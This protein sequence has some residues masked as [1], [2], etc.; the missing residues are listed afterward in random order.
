MASWLTHL[1]I[2]EKIKQKID[3]I[4]LPYF[5]MGSI[6]P[7]SGV[8]DESDRNYIPSKEV[9][10]MRY[11]KDDNEKDMDESAFY[12]SYLIPERLMTR[13]DSSR[14]FL[15]G[16]YFHLIAD[17][18][19]LE[20]YFRPLKAR[21]E[22]EE[23]KK[24]ADFV[25]FI[26][27][28]MFALDFEYLKEHGPGLV[29]ELKGFDGN[30]NAFYEFDTEYIYGCKDRITAFYSGEPRKLDREYE[31]LNDQLIEEFINKVTDKCISILVV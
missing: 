15:W 12:K 5:L 7:D 1:R 22:S 19:W 13:S 6:A 16:Y 21:F 27:E 20:D 30:I 3:G 24:D 17:K 4:D 28:E 8:P 29:E 31:Y 26:R 9:T 2:A 23:E 11:E 10:H 14:S 25:D 18:L